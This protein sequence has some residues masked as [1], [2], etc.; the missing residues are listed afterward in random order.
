MH[1]VG[2]PSWFEV[3]GL[4]S[5]IYHGASLHALYRS[6]KNLDVRK[7]EKAIIEVL[8]RRSLM[9][10][11]GLY[12]PYIPEK[13]DYLLIRENPDIYFGG[14]MH[15]YGIGQYRGCTIMNSSTWQLQTDFQKEQGHIPTPGIVLTMNLKNRQIEKK[16]FYQG[17]EQ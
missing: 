8:K 17:D 6:V 1:F 14:D 16:G 12:Q 5:I 9:T 7:P 11:Y 15:H 10:G 13:K 4:K 3:E 2:S